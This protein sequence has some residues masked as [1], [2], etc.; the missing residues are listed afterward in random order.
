MAKERRRDP[1]VF[2]CLAVT[3]LTYV[4]ASG[5]YRLNAT[6][7][8]HWMYT[9]SAFLLLALVLTGARLFEQERFRFARVAPVLGGVFA[10]WVVFLGGRTFARTF[11]WKD[12]RTFLERTIAAGGD[13]SRMFINLGALEMAEGN[14][15]KARAH[16]D[17]A[18]QQQP[19][20]PFAIIN[21]AALA[22]QEGDFER[23]HPL[24]LRAAKMPLVEAQAHELLTVLQHKQKGETNLTRMRLATRS[25]APNWSI[26]RRYIKLLT[27]SG[28]PDA[29]MNELRRCLTTEWYRAETWQ[30]LGEVLTKA[31]RAD[32][33]AEA[34]R[35]AE[36]YDV[37]LHEHASRG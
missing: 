16:L 33:A 28:A 24:L 9:P 8:E 27:E 3:L 6:V 18:L 13:S 23:A 30:L 29:A 32:E 7:A 12:Q 14:F 17:R 11:D 5:V 25:G 37:R 19:E 34:L 20:Q 35:R 10:L 36:L 1:A 31:G 15:D 22:V 4:P 2:A 26:Q 21:R